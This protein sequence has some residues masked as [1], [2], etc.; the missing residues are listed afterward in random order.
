[1]VHALIVLQ[2]TI[3][4]ALIFS[5]TLALMVDSTATS[6]V[7]PEGPPPLVT[8]RVDSHLFHVTVRPQPASD[9]YRAGEISIMLQ[10][11]DP[12]SIYVA[13]K[14][15]KMPDGSLVAMINISP[16]SERFYTV[17]VLD[18]QPDG[19]T[20]MLFSKPLT[21]IKKQDAEQAGTGQPA[22]A[23]ESKPE[24]GENPTPETKPAPR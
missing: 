24:S 11:S 14:A 17:N 16:E 10:R 22:T 4:R 3:M 19:R 6:T 13:L 1:V 20:L 21:E 2:N 7:L 8:K 5:L 15:Q 18:D 12:D 23:P 9:K